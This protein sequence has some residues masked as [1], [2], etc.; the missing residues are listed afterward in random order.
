MNTDKVFNQEIFW[1]QDVHDIPLSK[2]IIA[3][4]KCI[5]YLKYCPY[6]NSQIVS[7][8]V[9]FYDSDGLALYSHNGEFICPI[10]DIV[11]WA[12]ISCPNIKSVEKKK[13]KGRFNK[14]ELAKFSDENTKV[15]DL[16]GVDL[17]SQS[18]TGDDKIIDTFFLE[19]IK[20]D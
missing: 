3:A 9:D 6:I 20:M 16:T 14:K 17:D 11:A 4:I 5:T 10:D 15:I 12:H 7:G 8:H 13:K 1:S 2:G 18:L 19:K